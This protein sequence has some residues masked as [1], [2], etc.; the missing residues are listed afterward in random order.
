M[1]TET[2]KGQLL[3]AWGPL[4]AHL[5]TDPPAYMAWPWREDGE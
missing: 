4:P 3:L 5:L 2:R 1:P